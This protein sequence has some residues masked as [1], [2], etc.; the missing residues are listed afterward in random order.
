MFISWKTNGSEGAVEFMR[1]RL[2]NSET[3]N[4]IVYKSWAQDNGRINFIYEV[5]GDDLIITEEWNITRA[6]YDALDIAPVDQPQA[7]G[8]SVPLVE[9]DQHLSF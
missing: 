6:E 9:T 7:D 1:A 2:E 4:K 5:V 3:A 8:V